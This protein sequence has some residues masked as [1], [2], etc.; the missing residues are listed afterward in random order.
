MS[1]PS[2]Q[3]MGPTAGPPPWAVLNCTQVLLPEGQSRGTIF[4]GFIFPELVRSPSLGL[5][6]T[7]GMSPEFP[8]GMRA[9][10]SERPLSG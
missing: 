5:A 3:Y 4:P 1:W 2:P 8:L 10:G 6:I 7:P 9:W